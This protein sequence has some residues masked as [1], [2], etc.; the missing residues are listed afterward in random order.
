MIDLAPF[1][2]DNLKEEFERVYKLYQGLNMNGGCSLKKNQE[3]EKLRK[4]LVAL[5][6]E[7][8]KRRLHR[9]K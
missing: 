5:I 6:E 7:M 1:K 2:Y 4:Y 9:N 8:R 3:C